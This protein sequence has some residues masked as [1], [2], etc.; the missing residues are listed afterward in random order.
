MIA[1]TF[2]LLDIESILGPHWDEQ[3]KDLCGVLGNDTEYCTFLKEIDVGVIA[4][5]GSGS[6][7]GYS[8]I[9]V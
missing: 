7:E 9:G 8:E 2:E 3:L 5:E 4:P 6:I 1:G